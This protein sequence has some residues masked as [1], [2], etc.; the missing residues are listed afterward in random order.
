MFVCIYYSKH[1]WKLGLEIDF[2]WNKQGLCQKELSESEAAQVNTT[3][4][5]TELTMTV[6][7]ERNFAAFWL[8]LQLWNWRV[9]LAIEP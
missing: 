1:I 2:D 5:S 6:S 8:Y 9:A 4:S 7:A 3:T